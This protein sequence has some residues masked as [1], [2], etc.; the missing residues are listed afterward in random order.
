M[1]LQTLG[2]RW[3]DTDEIYG[4][5]NDAQDDRSLMSGQLNLLRRDRRSHARTARL[6]ESEARASHEA[7][8]QSI[9]ASDTACSEVSAVRTMV[10]AQQTKIGDL[11]AADRR[12][13]AQ[14]I[15]AL[16]MMSTL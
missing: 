13:Q 16:T 5:L 2:M 14:L 10:L 8:V 6:M 9:D 15:E 12:R 3:Q 1:G 7:W 4:R 11:W